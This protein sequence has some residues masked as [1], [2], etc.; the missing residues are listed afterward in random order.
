MAILTFGGGL[1]E[2]DDI[3]IDVD[4]CVEGQNF[5][6]S[7][8]QKSYR[9]R[10]PF[11]LKGTAPNGADIR[12]LMQLTKKSNLMTTL[13]QAGNTVYGV[14][15]SFAFTS[16]GT[17]NAGS[18]LRGMYWG[19]DDLLV[20]TDLDKLT[21]VKQWDGTTFSTMVHGIPAVTNFYAKYA[22]EFAGRVFYFNITTDAVDNAHVMY[23]SAFQTYNTLNTAKRSKD[24]TFT[25]GNE[26][27]FMTT[28]DLREING[29]AVFYKTLVISTKAGRTFRLTGTDSKS[30]D[31]EE[32]YA[33][34]ASV[35]DEAIVNIGNDV[36]WVRHGGHID[37]MTSTTNYGDVSA[38]DASK[39]IPNSTAGLTAA[40]TVY[41]MST[42]RVLFFVPNKILVFDKEIYYS[43]NLS[44]WSAY[45]TQMPS[46]LTCNAAMFLKSPADGKWTTYFGDA[47]GH[48]YDLNGTGAGG[49]SGTHS[50]KT[51]RKTRM[52]TELDGMR[53]CFVGRI[54][55]RRH[56]VMDLQMDLEWEDEGTTTTALIPL[57]AALLSAGT[58]LYNS[59]SSPV[60]YGDDGSLDPSV[61][62]AYYN[63]GGVMDA[64]VSTAG[65][66]PPGRG[67]AFFLTLSANTAVPFLINR[68]E[69]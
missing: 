41:D 68:L 60:Y 9:P 52:I 3:N 38:D 15:S 32:F 16:R 59:S 66:D 30:Y 22:V 31:F 33:G 58:N 49:D 57:K 46:N 35:G 37:F 63:M 26:A 48:I 69:V 27:F 8:F 56:G 17:V 21:P 19:L 29:V 54:V 20:V 47:T 40:M 13:T 11:D 34:S 42:Q 14:D 24:S 45:T 62:K 23:A 6:L 5:L 7:K 61:S 50:I 65:F 64:R 1:N 18:R 67:H 28:P 10:Q 36:M 12:G 53:N 25:T 39:W 2:Q 44:P 51:S 55:H 43:S 4:E